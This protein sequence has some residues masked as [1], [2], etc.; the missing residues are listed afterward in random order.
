MNNKKICGLEEMKEAI[1]DGQVANTN[2][3]SM[4][5]YSI[6]GQ[7]F[8]TLLE[9]STYCFSSDRSTDDAIKLDYMKEFDGKTDVIRT[10]KADG[11]INLYSALDEDGYYSYETSVKNGIPCFAWKYE[12]G[13]LKEVYDA[14]RDRGIVFE[15]DVY[16]KISKKYKRIAEMAR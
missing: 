5:I 16:A 2:V 4:S 8:D 6:D 3:G 11:T 7:F 1:L 15:N 12:F 13:S 9:I 10:T 14:F